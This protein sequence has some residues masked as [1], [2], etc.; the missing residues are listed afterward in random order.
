MAVEN[1]VASQVDKTRE[2]GDSYEYKGDNINE[3]AAGN[4]VI[5]PRGKTVASVSL[6]ITNTATAKIQ[7]TT[8]TVARVEAGS[9]VA[10]DWPDGGVTA[11]TGASFNPVTAVRLNVT[12]YTSGDV[13]MTAIA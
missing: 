9:A 3:V 12:A 10:I 11:S 4:W 5:L 8:D 2:F 7:Y 1:F 6:I 13:Y